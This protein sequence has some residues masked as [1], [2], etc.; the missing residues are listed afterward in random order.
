MARPQS[1]ASIFHEPY[2][3]FNSI[4]RYF[5]PCIAQTEILSHFKQGV[6]G[7]F[8]YPCNFQNN[9]FY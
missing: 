2:S 3:L 9:E 1:K 7:I 6:K 4:H 8:L 5:L